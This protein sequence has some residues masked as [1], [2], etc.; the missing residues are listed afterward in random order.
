MGRSLFQSSSHTYLNSRKDITEIKPEKASKKSRF[1]PAG[2][3]GLS[4]AEVDDIDIQSTG[5]S[6]GN[7]IIVKRE[8]F[9]P[10]FATMAASIV[11]V[12]AMENPPAMTEKMK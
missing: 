2:E 12:D 3:G 1:F 6:M 5:S 4:A 11:V 10:A 9:P 7:D 8:P